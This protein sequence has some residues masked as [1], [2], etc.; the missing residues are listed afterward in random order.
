MVRTETFVLLV[1]AAVLLAL[2]A[3]LTV[4]V[5]GLRLLPG[6]LESTRWLGSID[7]PIVLAVSEFLDII[8]SFDV[9]PILFLAL[10]PVVLLIWGRRA[11]IL[12]GISG[13]LT[14]LTAVSNLS[15]RARPTP[16][17]QFVE[18]VS[19]AGGYPSGHV[20]YGVMVFG[21]IAYIAYKQMRPGAIRSLVIVSMIATTVLM[22]PSRVIELD[23]WSADVV[24]SYLLSIPFLLLLIWLDRHPQL[25]PGS[26]IYDRAMRP[27]MAL[28]TRLFSGRH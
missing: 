21:M 27:Y 6:E 20:V 7:S 13:A 3:V 18:I 11:L 5:R 19:D 22:G 24:G 26:R 8:S 14:G 9:A 2:G 4:Y 10:L 17:F 15:D 1:P 23:H 12:F 25:Q 28:S 16:D